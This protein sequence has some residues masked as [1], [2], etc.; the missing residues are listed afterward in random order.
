VAPDRPATAF[1]L[2]SSELRTVLDQPRNDAV[3]TGPCVRS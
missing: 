1:A 2:D 3:N